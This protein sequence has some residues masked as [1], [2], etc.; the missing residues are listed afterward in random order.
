MDFRRDPK[1]HGAMRLKTI[2]S[3]VLRSAE[4]RLRTAL[5]LPPRP[6]KLLLELTNHCN[7]RCTTCSIWKTPAAQLRSEISVDDIERLFRQAGPDLLWLALGG[8]EVTLHPEF[9][10]IIGIARLHCPRLSLLTFTTNGL[11]PE[12]ALEWA[13]AIRDQGFDLF[14]TVSLDGDEE[15]HD[16]IRGVPGNYRLAEET[17]R[18]LRADGIAAHFGITLSSRNEGFVRGRYRE[19]RDR[20]KAVTFVSSGGIYRQENPTDDP[21]VLRALDHLIPLYRVRSPGDWFERLFL[22][23][24]RR[25][26]AEGRR[27]MPVPCESVT[28]SLHV[29]PDGDVRPCMFMPAIWNIREGSW[30]ESLRSEATALELQKIREGRCPRCW[31]NCYAPHSMLAHPLKSFLKSLNFVKRGEVHP[32]GLE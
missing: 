17:L 2:G 15:L 12:V 5:G 14:V 3:I 4:V 20:I 9:K 11:K 8:G 6:Y 26:Y 24:A 10:R 25:Y 18:L 27:E 7:S 30:K 21:A 31:M 23:L 1:Y 28:S 19:Y 13:R 32:D 22:K 29:R 16:S